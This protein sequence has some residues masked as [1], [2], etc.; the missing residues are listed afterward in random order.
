MELATIFFIFIIIELLCIIVIAIVKWKNIYSYLVPQAFFD[1]RIISKSGLVQDY[2]L[3]HKNK[4]ILRIGDN[5]YNIVPSFLYKNGIKAFQ[6]ILGN[7]NPL[8]FEKFD[9]DIDNELNELRK[10]ID[11]S[12]LWKDKENEWFKIMKLLIPFI[13]GLVLGILI[14]AVQAKTVTGGG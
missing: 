13:V 7:P 12:V 6:F 10:T 14:N 8:N 3:L 2:L 9:F 11:Y 4:K 1:I 5:D